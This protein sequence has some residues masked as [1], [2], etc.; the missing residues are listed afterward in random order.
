MQNLSLCSIT[1]LHKDGKKQ[2]KLYLYLKWF[3][4]NQSQ[5]WCCVV[6]RVFPA[7]ARASGGGRGSQRTRLAETE[8]GGVQAV[9][10]LC[11]K[12]QT[13]KKT[14]A[15][16]NLNKHLNYSNP[17]KAVTNFIKIYTPCNKCLSYLLNIKRF[18]PKFM[19]TKK[20]KRKKYSSRM[21]KHT[22]I[23]WFIK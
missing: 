8:V 10:R 11:L 12:K 4:E 18:L 13:N 9:K 7:L 22:K 14:K 5:V 20:N 6:L 16:H 23:K 19:F 21:K 15:K 1:I 17:R 2:E 3:Q